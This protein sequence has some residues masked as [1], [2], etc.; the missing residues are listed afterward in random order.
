MRS[1]CLTQVKYLHAGR[2]AALDLRTLVCLT[3]KPVFALM[4]TLYSTRLGLHTAAVQRM[5]TELLYRLQCPGAEQ[6]TVPGGNRDS[7]A[8]FF[9]RFFAIF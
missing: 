1:S 8:A 5:H 3:P 4:I 2:C 7:A 6:R 9:P